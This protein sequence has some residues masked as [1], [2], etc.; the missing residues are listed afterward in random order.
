LSAGVPS[1]TA[2]CA[3]KAVK[4]MATESAWPRRI[5]FLSMFVLPLSGVGRDDGRY[6][7]R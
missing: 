6:F 1:A 4:A 3:R 7:G 5:E 2:D